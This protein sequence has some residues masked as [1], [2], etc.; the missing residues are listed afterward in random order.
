MRWNLVHRDLPRGRDITEI[1]EPLGHELES[2]PVGDWVGPVRSGY[3]MH[4]V[5][6]DER[7]AARDPLLEEVRAAVETDLL[8][9]R[10]SQAEDV[11]YEALLER[12]TVR[13]IEDE[14]DDADRE[15]A[16]T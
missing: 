16:G 11:L 7:V 1:L 13:V 2:L 12:Y 8:S 15:D 5:L 3:G 10:S 14:A 9:N 6:L 4:L